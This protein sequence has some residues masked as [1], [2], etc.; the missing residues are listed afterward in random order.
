MSNIELSDRAHQELLALQSLSASD[1]AFYKQQQWKICNYV[2][3]LDASVIAIPKFVDSQLYPWEFF[4]LGLLAVVIFIAGIFLIREMGIALSKGRER[5]PALRVHFDMNALKAY[6]AGGN[7]DDALLKAKDKV[8]LEWFF[9][10]VLGT[11]F[12]LTLWLLFKLACL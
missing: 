9:Y 12:I 5:L 2:L 11:A 10:F 7:P 3:V 4:I 6:A 1:I 8:S